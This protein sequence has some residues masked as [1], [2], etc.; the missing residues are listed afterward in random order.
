MLIYVSDNNDA[1]KQPFVFFM[2]VPAVL[3]PYI[4]RGRVLRLASFS[5]AV[6]TSISV[7]VYSWLCVSVVQ[8][9][10]SQSGVAGALASAQ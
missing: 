5:L 9:R 1:G 2:Q 6:K 4:R 7:L 3:P 10:F 8:S